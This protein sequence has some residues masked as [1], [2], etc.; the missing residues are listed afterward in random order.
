VLLI[1]V[2][3]FF[4]YYIRSKGYC[5]EKVKFG[6]FKLGWVTDDHARRIMGNGVI[7]APH[8]FK[9]LSRRYYPGQE[10]IK[11]QN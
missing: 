11:Y 5:C 6:W 8:K 3:A 9:Q 7:I 4:K 10:G 1:F 2:Q